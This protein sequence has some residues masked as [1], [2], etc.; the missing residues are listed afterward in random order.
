MPQAAIVAA[1]GKNFLRAS[2]AKARILPDHMAVLKFITSRLACVAF[3]AAAA[4]SAPA[5]SRDLE[6][7]YRTE[8]LPIFVNYCY[9]CHGDGVKK[10]ELDMDLYEDIES[11][12]A[13][14]D[15]WQRIRDHIDFRLMPPPDEFA[16]SDE[17][18]EKL[19]AWIDDAVFPVDPENPDPGRVTLRRL[20][21]TEYRNTISDLLG[22]TVD[23]ERILPPDDSGYGFD[24]IGDVLT[25]SPAHL[26]RYLD[27]ART[28]L[29][30]A[31][32][33]D[34]MPMPRTRITGRDLEGQGQRQD[35]A[36]FFH[37]N[38]AAEA[39]VR[40][41]GP[42]RY[43]IEI[44]AGATRGGDELPRMELTID[45][46]TVAGWD[47]D[48][49]VDDPRV[50]TGEL[51]IDSRRRTTVGVAFTND[52][53][54]ASHP[55]PALRDRNLQV[56]GI[57]LHGPLDAPPPPKPETHRRIYGERAEGVEDLDYMTGVL[58]R[59]AR[60]AFRRPPME[61]E[62]ERYAVF[63]DL[64]K[65][66]GDGVEHAIQLALQAMLVSP[67]FLF[68][69]EPGMDAGT[70]EE[71]GKSLISEHA[72]ASRL[73]YFLWSSMP[74]E[75]LLELADAG[76]LRENLDGEL[77]RMIASEK[78]RDFVRNFAGQWL[79]LRDLDHVSPDHRNFRSFDQELARDMR[80]E[81]EMLF[82][83]ML[84][85]N[86]PATLLLDADFTFLNR[87]LAEHYGIPGVEG[88]GFALV[89]LEDQPRRGLL[90]HGSFLT[91]TSHPTRTSPV[92]RGKY[93][94]E[95]LLDTP[96]P[97]PPPNVPQLEA[98]ESHG[99]NLSLRVQMERHRDDPS[100]SSCHALMDP[101]G[102]GLENF[103]AIGRWREADNGL[104]IDSAGKLANGKTFSG[105]DELRRLITG[106]QRGDFHRAFATKLLTYSLGRGL[107]WYD[108]PAVA[109]I[110]MK[111][112]ADD[113][114]F[115][116][117]ISAV[118]SSVPFQYRRN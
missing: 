33:P 13:S 15:V 69:E 17:D 80:R 76:K 102:F 59:F 103:D 37:T 10:G 78:S 115:Q 101:I 68:R 43:R 82:A 50:Y 96:P 42:G 55:D 71:G 74:D 40:L 118:V 53:Y 20:N 67:A 91:L 104:A 23:V 31:L 46:E 98:P 89:S 77:A 92:L 73:S 84:K 72:L 32:H 5:A 27:A 110:V 112:E 66:E 22:V 6:A 36:Y 38:G 108:R 34:P 24:N 75:R 116:T 70:G 95:N 117:L 44:T 52:F 88:D 14:R 29:E 105:P 25:L 106:H 63:L 51:V 83:H 26:E 79:Q 21:R 9:D 113:G 2:H 90:G 8:I 81:T 3:V 61:G 47:V 16:P 99:E 7:V 48:G 114:R 107:E 109:G 65:E 11:M 18:R 58:R 93:V 60:K 30:T 54:D 41:P 28:A 19:I 4:T 62:V 35:P 97:P 56:N 39:R 12:I 49:M 64:A 100:C 111:A 87:R 57:E 85:E 94:L 45:G 1:A 86:H